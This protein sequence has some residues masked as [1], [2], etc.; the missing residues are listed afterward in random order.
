MK[1]VYCVDL[2]T[3][4][5][6]VLEFSGDDLEADLEYFEVS[7]PLELDNYDRRVFLSE[8]EAEAYLNTYL[9][10]LRSL[11]N[12]KICKSRQLPCMLYKRRYIVQTLLNSKMYTERHYKKNWKP[13]VLFNLHDQTYFLTVRLTQLE[14]LEDDDGVFYRYYFELP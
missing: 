6:E 7:S 11:D 14:E 2:D 13:G 9:K 5:P 10:T 1:L 3:P 12:A 4:R 8:V